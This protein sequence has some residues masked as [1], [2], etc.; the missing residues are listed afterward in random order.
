[1]GD[2]SKTDLL[3][4]KK[5]GPHVLLFDDRSI[6]E[7]NKKHQNFF[8]CSRSVLEWSVAQ[9]STPIPLT[10]IPPEQNLIM[11]VKSLLTKSLGASRHLSLL[12]TASTPPWT[13][14]PTTLTQIRGGGF[15]AIHGNIPH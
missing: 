5:L 10:V 14:T 11:I 6:P 12:A 13:P 9:N 2:H 7:I 8:R 3:H 1:M 4:L 15:L